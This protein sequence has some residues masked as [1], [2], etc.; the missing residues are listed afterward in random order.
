MIRSFAAPTLCARDQPGAEPSSDESGDPQA[1]LLSSEPQVE[2][3]MSRL[4]ID[5]DAHVLETERT[6]DYLDASE[7]KYRPLLGSSAKEPG[8]TF[9]L[10]DGQVAA[11]KGPT[12]TA[13]RL[14]S[15]STQLGRTLGTPEAARATNA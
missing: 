7:Q 14:R 2:V 10:V 5:S 6:W 13:Q 9:W 15:N 11:L 1:R 8:R 3:L 12:L 4:V